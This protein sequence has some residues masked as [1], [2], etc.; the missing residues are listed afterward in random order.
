MRRIVSIILCFLFIN[1]FLD[2]KAFSQINVNEQVSFVKAKPIWPTGRQL[3]KNLSI[4]FR[5]SFSV[6]GD[7]NSVVKITGSS[8]YRVFLNDVFIGHGPARAAHGFYRLDELDITNKLVKGTNILTI[9]VAGYNVNSYYLLDQPSFLQAEIIVNGNIVAA[10]GDLGF[11]ATEIKNRVQ[12]VPRYSFQRPFIEVYNLIPEHNLWKSDLSVTMNRLECEVVGNKEIIPRRIKY[13][14]FEIISP[15]RLISNGKVKTGQKRNRYWKDRAVKNIGEE[16]GGFPENELSINPSIEL[17]EM[18]RISNTILNTD[19]SKN[20]SSNFSENSFQI[21]DFGFNNTGFIGAE[22]SCDEP[23]TV[24]FTFD[25]ILS[26]DDVDFKRLGCINAVTYNLAPGKYKLESFEPYTLRYLKI[27]V[28]NG[29]CQIKNIYLREYV[30]SDITNATFYCNDERINRIYR[31]GVET[32]RQNVVD[33][34]MD[35]PSRERAGWLCD[36]YFSAR[37]ASDLSGNTLVEKNFLENYL[38]PEYFKDLPKGMLPM[39]YPADH[40]NGNFIPNWAMWFV[41][42]L[43]EYQYRSGDQELVDALKYRVLELIEYFEKFKNSDGLLESQ[44]AA[45]DTN[46]DGIADNVTT[47][48]YSYDV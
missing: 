20:E 12:K 30:N 26:K 14:D 37:V 13:S 25:E 44:V 22:I 36:S 11:T 48:S 38:L 2:K 47:V 39:C 40:P 7:E 29:S 31:A 19:Y 5:A 16:L 4:G 28:T 18:D 8:L 33:V 3:E 46:D 34:F 21:V 24:Y 27:I 15:S 42:E 35:C 17:Q 10:T 41:L 23:C 45:Q 32:F 43:E 1:S 9:E 6:S